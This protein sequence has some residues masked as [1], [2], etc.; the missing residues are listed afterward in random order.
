MGNKNSG[1]RRTTVD[2]LP[3]DWQDIM[4]ECGEEGGSAVEARALLGIGMSA[5][6]TLLEDSDIFRET[7]KRRK[8]LCQVWWERLGRHGAAGMAD[9]N[10]TVWI[11]NMKNRF[12]W[13]DRQNI[14]HTTGGEKLPSLIERR[15]VDPS[16]TDA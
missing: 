9:I 4:T 2:D 6:E 1:R 8:A 13:H 7:E 3:N 16:D 14:D 15:I 11:F 10:P 5:W 12:N